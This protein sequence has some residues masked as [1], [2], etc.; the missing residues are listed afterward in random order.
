MGRQPLQREVDQSVCGPVRGELVVADV[1]PRA[2]DEILADMSWE[3]NPSPKL[4]EVSLSRPVRPGEAAPG[5]Q[6]DTRQKQMDER[7]EH[8]ESADCTDAGAVELGL[9]DTAP[10]PEHGQ[11]RRA[12]YPLPRRGRG[13]SSAGF[14]SPSPGVFR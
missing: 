14:R 7:L 3:Q 13:R 6:D 10:M 12:A 5:Q 8:V 11:E 9:P 1:E 4:G 2:V